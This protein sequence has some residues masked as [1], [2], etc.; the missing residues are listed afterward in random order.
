MKK[1]IALVV[2][3][4]SLFNYSYAGNV[5]LVDIF[6]I[7]KDN[8][9]INY[10]KITTEVEN[11]A[12]TKHN[13]IFLDTKFKELNSFT[14][15]KKCANDHYKFTTIGN[16]IYLNYV[17]YAHRLSNIDFAVYAFDLNFKL[18]NKIEFTD[19]RNGD[20]IFDDQGFTSYSFYD[21]KTEYYKI[22]RFN[23]K[24][25]KISEYDS[26]T[27]IENKTKASLLTQLNNTTIIAETVSQKNIVKEGFINLKG[28]NSN[29]GK[30]IFST[31]LNEEDKILSHP[32]FFNNPT[33]KN[34]TIIGQFYTNM[35]DVYKKKPA[36][37]YIFSID[38]KGKIISKRY[39]EFKTDLSEIS[40]IYLSE[41]FK[42]IALLSI[43][44]LNNGNIIYSGVI[45]ESKFNYLFLNEYNS[46]FKAIKTNK[47]KLK[48][49]YFFDINI[50]GKTIFATAI[51]NI[52]IKNNNQYI[53]AKN[54]STINN[55]YSF[56][57]YRDYPN[58]QLTTFV[59]KNNI[60]K[61]YQFDIH[62]LEFEHYA[63]PFFYLENVNPLE[64]KLLKS[65]KKDSGELEYQTISI[66][67]NYVYKK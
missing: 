19:I 66:E 53:K 40:D 24:F 43:D 54:I 59:N 25:E 65:I 2:L 16:T 60:N 67:E 63:Q 46:D 36:G 50:G 47:I 38:A 32:L 58:G 22:E 55:D 52:N 8:K 42:G 48:E 9:L 44:Q 31:Q 15:I 17:E 21:E 34:Y 3:V 35:S 64:C 5:Y 10:V 41:K 57:I 27:E 20:I 28:I 45:R 26:R 30:T 61:C 18:K 12:N 7:K 13:F 1:F 23:N 11:S 62:H 29:N 51:D 4:I 49:D 56:V 37:N 14:V 33:Q 6:E 39:N